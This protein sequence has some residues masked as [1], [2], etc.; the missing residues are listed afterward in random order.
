MIMKKL[1]PR[2]CSTAVSGSSR[3]I[4]ISFRENMFVVPDEVPTAEDGQQIISPDAH[5]M[6]L[7]PM[8]CPAHV[9]IFKQGIKSYRD[10]PI[11]MA[12]FGCCHRNEPHGAL[13]GLMRVRQMT[14]DDAHIFCREDQIIAEA[15]DFCALVRQVYDDLGFTDVSV[16]TRPAA[17]QSRR[18]PMRSGIG[19]KMV[20]ARPCQRLAWHG[21]NCPAR[22][23]FTAR[24]LNIICAIR[25]AARGNAPLCS[26][27]LCCPSALTPPILA[28]MAT[29]TVR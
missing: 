28:K 23:R 3:A 29:S 16:K 7:K 11:R 2:K 14:Q 17:R 15:V 1:K 5:L 24:K 13:H 26:S 20:C 6:A 21:M 19:L 27:T 25:L 10:L 4:G 22:E 8:N 12:E 9:Q 18:F